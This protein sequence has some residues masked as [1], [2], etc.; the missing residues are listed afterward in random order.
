MKLNPQTLYIYSYSPESEFRIPGVR[1]Y[2]N[3]GQDGFLTGDNH[4]TA[5]RVDLER[6]E[7]Y[8]TTIHPGQYPVVADIE[9][10]LT[11]MEHRQIARKLRKRFRKMPVGIYVQDQAAA[12]LASYANYWKKI[13]NDFDFGIMPLHDLPADHVPY[14]VAAMRD[15][16]CNGKP[17]MFQVSPTYNKIERERYIEQ[18]KQAKAADPNAVIALFLPGHFDSDARTLATELNEALT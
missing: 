8:T 13:L 16:I 12:Y 5:R 15:W 7:A 11:I 1:R 6:I 17:M 3:I 4:T 2:Q 14:H 10:Y 9:A 18:A